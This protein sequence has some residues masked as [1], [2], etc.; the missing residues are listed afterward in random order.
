MVRMSDLLYFFLTI[1]VA[2]L[3][4]MILY[5]LKFPAGAM[6]G[7]MICVGILN[8]LTGRAFMPSSVKILTKTVAGLFVGMSMTMEMVRNMKRLFKPVIILIGTVFALCLCAGMILYHVSTLDAVTALFCVAPGGMTD[9]T[10]MTMDMG[11]D[12][13]VVAVLQVLRLLSV[14]CISMPLARLLGRKSGVTGKADTTTSLNKPAL[15]PEDRKKGILLASLVAVIGG[16]IGL[17][18]SKLLNFSVL[19]LICAM[20]AAAAVNMKTGK[21][22]MPKSVRRVTQILSGALI[23]TSV[24]YDS[25]TR[26]QTVLLPAVFICCGFVLINLILA[27]LLRKSCKLDLATAVLSTAAGG[28]TEAALVAPDLDA[29]PSVVSVLQ[30]SRLICTT[31]CYPILVQVVYQLL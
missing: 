28:A 25:L 27:F 24:T 11:G 1:A 17:G 9:M 8:I 31:A 5:R 12:A 3:G 15:C 23:G 16:G 10:L 2:A 20:V 26:L 19:I 4:G 18:L 21:L 29:D 7:A 6:V 14:Y 22:Y 13:A 30:I